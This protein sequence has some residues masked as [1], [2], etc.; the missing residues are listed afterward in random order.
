MRIE[1]DFLAQLAAGAYRASSQRVR[2]GEGG[3]RPDV[4]LPCG[5][6]LETSGRIPPSPYRTR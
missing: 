2:Y 3:M 5:G 6:S 4:S 1:E